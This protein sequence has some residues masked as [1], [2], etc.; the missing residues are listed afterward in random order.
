MG[1]EDDSG[2]ER[3]GGDDDRGREGIGLS[4]DARGE[5]GGKSAKGGGEG[6]RLPPMKYNAGIPHMATEDERR[7]G[8]QVKSDYAGRSA[9]WYRFNCMRGAALALSYVADEPGK[10]SAVPNRTQQ[11]RNQ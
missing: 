1:R 2:E 6:E 3:E 7:V 10:R 4:S 11:Q 8:T 9:Q 5:R